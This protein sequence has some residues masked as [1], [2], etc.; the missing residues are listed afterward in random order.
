MVIPPTFCAHNL[1][2]YV[3]I[4]HAVYTCCEGMFPVIPDDVA[5]SVESLIV[6]LFKSVFMSCSITFYIPPE[7]R[8]F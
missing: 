6:V 8:L 3:S 2:C 1:L 5:M 4:M 7:C